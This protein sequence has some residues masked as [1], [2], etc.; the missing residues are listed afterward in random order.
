MCG[1][2]Q[3]G[4][5]RAR[6]VGPCRLGHG[7]FSSPTR[8]KSEKKDRWL[9]GLVFI[10]ICH[11]IYKFVV[12]ITEVAVST[13]GVRFKK[14]GYLFY[15]SPLPLAFSFVVSFP[16][17]FTFRCALHSVILR[18]GWQL[19][20]LVSHWTPL[21][22]RVSDCMLKTFGHPGNCAEVELHNK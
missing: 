22:L 13:N 16:S 20:I 12:A 4:C 5:G 8:S 6:R 7:G 10:V 19:E 17:E 2:R 11:L 18:H 21:P 14:I 15:H 1:C 9:A 3:G